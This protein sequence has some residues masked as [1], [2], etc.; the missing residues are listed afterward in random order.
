MFRRRFLFTLFMA[1][2]IGRPLLGMEKNEKKLSITKNHFGLPSTASAGQY[3]SNLQLLASVLLAQAEVAE[4]GVKAQRVDNA[5]LMLNQKVGAY[6]WW[7]KPLDSDNKKNKRHFPIHE[8]KFI[9]PFT[10]AESI[11]TALQLR[12]L[13]A[14]EILPE[15]LPTIDRLRVSSNEELQELGLR[16][17]HK[18]ELQR[19][20]KKQNNIIN[21]VQK[22][23]CDVMRIYSLNGSV[24]SFF[25]HTPPII[26]NAFGL[27]ISYIE[28]FQ[29]KLL[30]ESCVEQIKDQLELIVKKF[31]AGYQIRCAYFDM[32]YEAVMLELTAQAN[33]VFKERKQ[34]VLR[35]K[36][37]L[38]GQKDRLP[39]KL[40]PS[41][42]EAM[43]NFYKQT[44]LPVK[45]SKK[46][47]IPDP[48]EQITAKE[49]QKNIVKD[50]TAKVAPVELKLPKVCDPDGSYVEDDAHNLFIVI[51]DPK[52]K[53]KIVLYKTEQ[54]SPRA[55]PLSFHPHVQAWY[56][57]NK[58]ETLE[59][60]GYNDPAS[61]KYN[62]R[63][64]AI[65]YHTF[66]SCIDKYLPIWGVESPAVNKKG[67]QIINVNMP[68]EIITED[69]QRKVVLFTYAF[70]L[71][72]QVCFHRCIVEV[73]PKMLV[74]EYTSHKYWE[75]NYPPLEK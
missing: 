33:K 32:L 50:Q 5:I 16:L 25:D 29:A 71:L 38:H 58:G 45:L 30:E 15:D 56:N 54:H 43:L 57:E 39:D 68:G 22:N 35:Y 9:A 47:T 11:A 41:T 7:E 63:S 62:Y 48:L 2:V 14:K 19:L 72:T 67:E 75:V 1:G 49:P 17:W 37:K 31:D 42:A 10:N 40:I 6:S 44:D 46:L 66:A 4:I 3:L 61:K 73:T 20:I 23:F 26:R 27:I 69:G 8:Y 13:M 53:L 24:K 21:K 60:Q 34:P 64:N 65:A 74:D 70:N 52:N 59:A 51:Q 28:E 36:Q 12:D 55:Y 18:A